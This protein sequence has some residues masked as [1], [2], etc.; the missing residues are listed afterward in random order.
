MFKKVIANNKLKIT[1][2][3]NIMFYFKQNNFKLTTLEFKEKMKLEA[4]DPINLAAICVATVAK[5]LDNEYLM[6]RIDG[7]GPNEVDMFCYHRNSPYI[8][9]AG[10]CEKN[11]I[12]LQVPYSNV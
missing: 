2:H 3:F 4:V 6:I 9:P 11:N 12:N 8:F 5:V 7:V 1:L 10:F